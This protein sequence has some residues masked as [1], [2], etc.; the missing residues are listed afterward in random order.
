MAFVKWIVAER[1]K[2]LRD[3]ISLNKKK[4]AYRA[5]IPGHDR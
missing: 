2:T 3:K 4:H 1:K 5:V